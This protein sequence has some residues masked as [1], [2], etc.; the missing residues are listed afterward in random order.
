M[1]IA[2]AV[3]ATLITVGSALVVSPDF[4]VRSVVS[5]VVAGLVSFSAV[6]LVPNS[7]SPKKV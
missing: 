2:K 5:A 6:Y 4:G 3:V 1:T 7:N